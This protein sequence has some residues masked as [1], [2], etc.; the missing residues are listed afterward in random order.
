MRILAVTGITGKSGTVFAEELAEHREEL[1]AEFPDGI[2][3]IVRETSDTGR[4]RSLFPEAE[5]RAGDLT[6]TEFLTG[7]FEHVDTVM[8][9]AGIHW[10][11]EVTKAASECGIRRLI[12]VH[13]AGIYSKYKKAGEEYRQIDAYVEEQCASHGIMLTVL[14]PTMI[15]GN[16]KDRN[17]C[18]FIRL[19]DRLPVMPVI[20]HAG[21]Q[22]QPV[23]YEDLGKAYYAVLFSEHQ[24]GGRSFILSGGEPILLKELF[25][26]IAKGLGKKTRFLN[27]PFRFA[28]A[29]AWCVF[30]V[31]FGKS[32]FRE[33]V[34]RLCENRAYPHTEAAEAFGYQ[35]RTFREG[36]IREIKEYKDFE[37][38]KR[39]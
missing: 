24:T 12:A 1:T 2:R 11:R 9:I 31:S 34:Q 35:P 39:K 32:D 28:Y 6:D 15:Y 14:R 13:T 38:N 10:S 22:L 23:H 37:K 17:I 19:V 16:L 30:I 8:H 3:F 21:Y 33:K 27:V 26:E 4:I 25:L 36:I 5:Y 29:G 18:T 20:G 7:A